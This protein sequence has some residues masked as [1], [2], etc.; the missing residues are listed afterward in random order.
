[1][2]TM[3]EVANAAGV[4]VA[5]VSR[6]LNGGAKVHPKTIKRVEKVIQELHYM[7]NVSAQNL[8]KN[9]TR[10]ILAMARNFTHPF[11][12]HVFSGIG[13]V[14]REE[15]YHIVTCKNDGDVREAVYY[16]RMLENQRA[17]GI[18]LLNCTENDVWI[19]PYVGKYPI[20]QCCEYVTEFETAKVIVDH[21]KAG[22][23]ST[24]YLLSLGH[25]KIGFMGAENNLS[26]TR[27]RYAGYCRAM[28]EAGY[29]NYIQVVKADADYSF[30][31]GRLCTRELLSKNM[32]ERPTAIF[33]V[34]DLLALGVIYEAKEMNI[35]VPK[36][37]SVIGCD[38]LDYATLYHPLLTSVHIPCY[39]LGRE[40]AKR[41]IKNIRNGIVQDEVCID[42]YLKIRESCAPVPAGNVE[43]F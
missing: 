5:T 32:E 30:E 38:D 2:S 36:D 20:V 1:M 39:E 16:F 31:G 43:D 21:E 4:S 26:S 27:G 37:L 14:G 12:A 28:I 7:P 35:E 13:D 40:C 19:K 34:S 3:V 10:I 42:T 8:R 33:C 25:K 29:E 18:I 41:L 22:Y 23:E 11:Y 15:G 17:D 9:E 6:V 24:N